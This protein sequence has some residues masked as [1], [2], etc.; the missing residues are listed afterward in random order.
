MAGT[1]WLE[2]DRKCDVPIH[3]SEYLHVHRGLPICLMKPDE[4]GN[5]TC[6]LEAMAAA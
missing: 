3:T 4:T 6:F 2:K 5:M 1:P